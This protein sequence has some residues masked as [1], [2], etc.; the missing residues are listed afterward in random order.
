[1]PTEFFSEFSASILPEKLQ[2][3]FFRVT[4]TIDSYKS[5]SNQC[6]SELESATAHPPKNSVHIICLHDVTATV[7]ETPLCKI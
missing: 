1:M 4:E 6:Y 7:G 2:S 3:H 5:D